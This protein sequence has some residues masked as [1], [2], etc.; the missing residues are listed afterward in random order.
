MSKTPRQ[1]TRVVLPCDLSAPSVARKAVRSLDAIEPLRDDALLAAT[2]LVSNAVRHGGCGHDDTI[3]MV[4]EVERR[5]VR[6]TVVDKARSGKTPLPAEGPI[7]GLGGMGLRLVQMLARRW[8]VE[9]NHK[10]L[11]WAELAV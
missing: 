6:I 9:R 8:G 4:A 5:T 7:I 3:E 2:E 11:V 10:L 1:A